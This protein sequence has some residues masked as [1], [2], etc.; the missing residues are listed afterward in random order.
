MERIKV[1]KFGGSSLADKYKIKNVASIIKNE[2]INNIGM[3]IVVSAMGKTTAEL[4]DVASDF[5]PELSLREMDMLL[6]SGER[7]SAS[8]L[9]MA[10]NAL[11]VKAI[12]FTGSQAGIITDDSHTNARIIE[13][14]PWRVK[15]ALEE[16]YVV[17]VS[18]FQGVSFKKEITTLGRGGSD[19]TAAALAA[20]LKVDVCEIYSDVDGVYAADPTIV[21]YDSKIS[22]LTYE[23]MQEFSEAGAKVLH[24]KS[25]EFAKNADVPIV[26]KSA[27]NIENEGTII[28]N[29]EGRIKPR[30]VG[31]ASEENVVMISFR[32]T[33]SDDYFISLTNFLSE[34]GFKLKQIT[35]FNSGTGCMGAFVLSKKDNYAVSLSLKNEI[36][37]KEWISID[38]DL[39]AVSLVGS[40]IT[41]T[42]A[43]LIKT[44]YLL[45][46]HGI[47]LKSIHTSS[48]RISYII[49]REH[50]DAAVKLLYTLIDNKYK[51]G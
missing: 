27:F 15:N 32:E 50:L 49:K 24:P 35:T 22:S 30:I 10:L 40:G 25:V 51:K 42:M 11:G 3:V 33:M 48:F 20:A 21:G 47:S 4:I 12:S 9:T 34:K 28:K 44:S 29:L 17:V 38:N 39:S 7:V 45:R 36:F 1:L 31:I 46:E 6:T 19:T 5:S 2:H 14:R 8:L 13:V 37:A 41:D 23:E 18:G 26:C 16:D 43:I